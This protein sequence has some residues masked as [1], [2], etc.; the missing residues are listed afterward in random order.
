MVAVEI[1]PFDFSRL[2]E[3]RDGEFAVSQLPRLAKECVDTSGLLRWRVGGGMHS[4]GYPQLLL[5]ITGEVCVTCQRCLQPYICA[6]AS[7]ATLLLARNELQ[8]DQMEAMFDD[9]SLDVIAVAS[10]VDLVQLIEDEALLS[11]P[12]A[13]KHD[14]CPSGE[15]ASQSEIATKKLS[16]FAA[17]KKF[18]H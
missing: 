6:I 13:P 12:Q 1:N 7:N 18:G 16:P 4:G 11:M 15:A 8:A 2:G 9:D 10:V 5:A 3:Q 17:L 14:R